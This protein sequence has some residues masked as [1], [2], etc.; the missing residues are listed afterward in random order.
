MTNTELEKRILSTNCAGLIAIL[1]EALI[2]NFYNSIEAIEEEDHP[3]LN[4]L[5]NHSRAI[6]TELLVQFN[7]KD[8]ISKDI[9]EI[10]LYINNEIT[11]GEYKKDK[12]N[13]ENCIKVTTPILEAFKELEI[14]ET[15]K[16]VAG[17]TY[18]KANLDEHTLKGN[19]TFEG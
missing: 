14:K 18:G 5:T 17:L 13:Y 3:K 19:K 7:G 9:R 15:P 6:L 11:E 1:Y 2:N 4:E 8:R 12:I 10:N 16:T